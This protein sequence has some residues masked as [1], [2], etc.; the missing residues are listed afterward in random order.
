MIIK[1]WILN[2]L[3]ENNL[4]K[5]AVY[6]LYSQFLHECESLCD[7]DSYKRQVRKYYEL[8]ADGLDVQ[9]YDDDSVLRTEAQRQKQIDLNSQLRKTNREQYRVYNNVEEIYTQYVDLLSNVDLT[10]FKIKSHVPSESKK[11]LIMQ[12]SDLHF[13]SI[14]NSVESAGN[15]YDFFIA[16]RRLKKFVTEVVQIGKFKKITEMHIF[17][18]G[19]FINSNRRISELLSQA[20]SLVR[21]SLLATNLL[22]QAFVELAKYFNITVSCVVGNESRIDEDFE[23]SDILLSQNYDY[24]I[25]ENLKMIFN[26]TPIVFNKSKNLSQTIVKINGKYNALLL[27]GNQLKMPNPEKDIARILQTY[28]YNDVKV[29]GVFYGHYHTPSCSSI[30]NRSGS[31][32]GGNAYSTNELGFIS[33][34]SQNYYIVTEDGSLSSTI[35]DLQNIDDVVGYDI[36]ELLE[37]YNVRSS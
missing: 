5:L 25:N 10:K 29:S 27:H 18:T 22:Q 15:N 3:N 12:L 7:L 28:T 2:K 30:F 11:V 8:L 34:A 20:T 33:R 21:A 13:N 14:V 16:S 35:V 36:N 17:Q 9:D 37:R 6:D 26:K 24:L 31:M 32:M 1:T 4:D 23:S 19:D